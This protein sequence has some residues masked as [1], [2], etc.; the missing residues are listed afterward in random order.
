ML[1][2]KHGYTNG[3]NELLVLI[4]YLGEATKKL[5]ALRKNNSKDYLR[6]VKWLYGK[7]K[8]R[9]TRNYKRCSLENEEL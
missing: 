8:M 1:G 7:S 2:S 3:D 5:V 6:W 4:H 9:G